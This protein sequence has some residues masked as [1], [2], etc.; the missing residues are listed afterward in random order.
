MIG[1][2]CVKF[3]CRFLSFSLLVL[4][5]AACGSPRVIREEPVVYHRPPPPVVKGPLIVIDAGHGGKDL[6][7][8]SKSP[9]Y[10]EKKLT[11]QTSFLLDS[12]LKKL[13]YRTAMTRNEDIFVSLEKRA[14]IAND[15]NPRIFVSVHYNSAENKQADGIEVFYYE[16]PKNK[17]RS[18]KSKALA[19][20]VLGE[21]IG[22]TK[23][24]SRGVKHGNLH[25]IR[26]TNMPAIL[27]EAGFLTNAKEREKIM[28]PQYMDTLA[29]AVAKGIDKHARMNR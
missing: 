28:D 4:L 17:D 21:I 2:L 27:I 5:F 10:E 13:G 25:V 22:A 24:K 19:T 8:S 23:S 16:S 7:T 6:G 20:S 1:R 14:A 15:L 11:L 26:E 3:A 12:Y 9:F 18:E 29:K